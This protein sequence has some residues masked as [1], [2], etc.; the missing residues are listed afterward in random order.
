MHARALSALFYYVFTG[1]DAGDSR[2]SL[3]LR[4]RA[5]LS[6]YFTAYYTIY[7]D[8]AEMLLR[9][10]G[11]YMLLTR[12]C[13]PLPATFHFRNFTAKTAM[14]RRTVMTANRMERFFLAVGF[15]FGTAAGAMSP[16][17]P[18]LQQKRCGRALIS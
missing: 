16:A 8:E 5:A 7:S 3:A 6:K 14:Y 2:S 17:R 13:F 18:R 11:Y 4:A 1:G 9:Q 12:V 15:L 10:P